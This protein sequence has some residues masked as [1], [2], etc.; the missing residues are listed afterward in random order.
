MS[1]DVTMRMP[2]L[3][4]TEMSECM[5]TSKSVMHFTLIR[6]PEPTMAVGEPN[7]QKGSEQTSALLSA[8]RLAP[9]GLPSA[10]HCGHARRGWQATEPRSGLKLIAGDGRN[11][12]YAASEAA[13]F[14]DGKTAATHRWQRRVCGYYSAV[15]EI[16]AQ[17]PRSAFLLNHGAEFSSPWLLTRVERVL[18]Q[19]G[20]DPSRTFYVHF[21]VAAYSAAQGRDL[22]QVALKMSSLR[23]AAGIT[24]GSLRMLPMQEPDELRQAFFNIYLWRLGEAARTHATTPL[25]C[26]HHHNN[27]ANGTRPIEAASRRALILG[28]AEHAWRFTVFLELQRRGILSRSNWSYPKSSLCNHDRHSLAAR[29]SVLDAQPLLGN[30]SLLSSFCGQLPKTLDISLS[31]WS[32]GQT[33]EDGINPKLWEHASFGITFDTSVVPGRDGSLTRSLTEKAFKP[34]LNA[35]PFVLLGSA[36]SLH[37]LRAMGFRTF[38]SLINESYDAINDGQQRV[39][40]ALLEVERLAGLPKSAW[41]SIFP[42]LAHNQRQLLCGGLSRTMCVAACA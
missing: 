23:A 17:V 13:G 26:H 28:G 6:V 2:F 10:L 7:V 11:A 34:M 33:V 8:A 18:R 30:A 39:L 22:P 20:I 40:A 9:K 31:A 19:C 38:A 42:V 27:V 37:L 24:S 21:N 5:L 15:A 14:L 41:G 32:K 4:G 29:S 36:G 35:R 16:M 25:V 12:H 3:R 1:C